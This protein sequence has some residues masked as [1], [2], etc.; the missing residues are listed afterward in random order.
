MTDEEMLESAYNMLNGYD[1]A[2]PIDEGWKSDELVKLLGDIEK[3][4]GLQ[5]VW[6]E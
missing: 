1:D 3:R 2:G 5:R 4:L 6:G